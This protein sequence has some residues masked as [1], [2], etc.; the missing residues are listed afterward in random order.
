VV[1][2]FIH[3]LALGWTFN[4][5]IGEPEK[6]TGFYNRFVFGR[7]CGFLD[8]GHFFNCAII[9]YLY[10]AEEAKQ[11]GEE[12]EIRQRQWRSKE[13]LILLRKFKALSFLTDL[14]WGYATS[15]DTIEDRSSDWFGIRLGIKMRAHANNGRIIDFFIEQWPKLVKGEVLG[16]EKLSVIRKIFAIIKLMIDSFRYRL[17]TGGRFDI[18]DYMKNFFKHR[19][20]IDPENS[21]KVPAGIFDEIIHFYTEKYNSGEWSRYTARGWEVVIPQELWERVVRQNSKET[22]WTLADTGLP[23]K[24]QLKENGEKVAPYFREE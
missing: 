4:P 10:G 8:L 3:L 18:H 23:I 24:I 9:A 7:R 21:E 15:A 16:P 2:N 22:D 6:A 17:G 12:I 19:D 14:F 11:R 20:A 1:D 5:G 13:W